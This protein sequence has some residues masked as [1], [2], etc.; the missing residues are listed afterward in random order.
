MP[1]TVDVTVHNRIT[2][3][4]IDVM[5]GMP[6]QD[7]TSDLTTLWFY[8]ASSWTSEPT[9]NLTSPAL[10]GTVYTYIYG[11]TTYYRHV[12][13]PYDPAEDAFYE[14]YSGGVLSNQIAVKGIAI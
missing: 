8:L 1:N 3:V 13:S 4:E 2:T 14:T 5:R 11:S 12:P 7:G 10:G 9:V 6:G